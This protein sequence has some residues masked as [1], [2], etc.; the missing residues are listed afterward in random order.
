MII[1]VCSIGYMLACSVNQLSWDCEEQVVFRILSTKIHC[2]RSNSLLFCFADLV[3]LF[4]VDGDELTG[5]CYVGNQDINAL[6]GFVLAPLFTY[7][8]VGTSFLV[9]GFVSLFRIQ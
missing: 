1:T 5:L 2:F 3:F 7:L 8:V 4:Q 6:T 9:A